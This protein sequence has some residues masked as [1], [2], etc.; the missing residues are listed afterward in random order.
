MTV[1]RQN[2]TIDNQNAALTHLTLFLYK[3]GLFLID[4]H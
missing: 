2:P 4:K 3:Q 1:I